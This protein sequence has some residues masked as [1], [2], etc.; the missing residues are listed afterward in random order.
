MKTFLRIYIGEFAAIRFEAE[1]VDSGTLFRL[2]KNK[3]STLLAK[4]QR[5][6]LDF[7]GGSSQEG[8]IRSLVKQDD[9]ITVHCNLEINQRGGK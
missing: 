6:H 4:G 1:Q 9:F 5:C 2:P 7:P 3:M 8:F